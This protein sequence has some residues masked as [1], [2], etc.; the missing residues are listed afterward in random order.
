MEMHC[1]ELGKI[2]KILTSS[3]YLEFGMVALILILWALLG[4]KPK[5]KKS[6]VDHFQEEN[7]KTE[8][9]TKTKIGIEDEEESI[10]IKDQVIL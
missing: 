5:S 1:G 3:L 8:V 6:F 4:A 10:T 2:E 7:E 9:K